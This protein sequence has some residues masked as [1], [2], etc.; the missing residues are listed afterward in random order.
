MFSGAYNITAK[1]WYLSVVHMSGVS[2]FLVLLM[3]QKNALSHILATMI[4]LDREILL[5]G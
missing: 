3:L 1:G 2:Q 5:N 4:M